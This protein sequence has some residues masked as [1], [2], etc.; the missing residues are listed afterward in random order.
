MISLKNKVGPIGNMHVKITLHV[1]SMLHIHIVIL[2]HSIISIHVTI[3][4]SSYNKC[5]KGRYD[6][7][8]VGL[9][10]WIGFLI[11]VL[12]DKI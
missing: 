12:G 6:P 7:M 11:H 8:L 10:A 3:D 4:G 2:C 9:M 5:D 1:I